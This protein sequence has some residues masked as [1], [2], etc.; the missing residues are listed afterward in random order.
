M[1][2][3][4]VFIAGIICIAFSFQ[5][6]QEG[7]AEIA[8]AGMTFDELQKRAGQAERTRDEALRKVDGLNST[9]KKL[10]TR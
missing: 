1:Q 7:P 8:R 6:Y 5:L 2:D 9:L 4:I 10:E 3:C